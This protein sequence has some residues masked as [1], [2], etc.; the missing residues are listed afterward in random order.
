ME[1]HHSEKKIIER[2]LSNELLLNTNYVER[3]N[4]NIEKIEKKN[5]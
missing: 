3:E 2:N 4:I 5:L 1:S